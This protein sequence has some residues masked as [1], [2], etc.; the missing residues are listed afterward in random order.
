MQ[1]GSFEFKPALWPTIA[2]LIIVPVFCGMG[3]WQLSRA[4]DKQERLQAYVQSEQFGPANIGLD[5]VFDAQPGKAA[6]CQL[7]PT[8]HSTRPADRALPAP[9][10]LQQQGSD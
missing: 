1:I 4:V 7:W 6:G 10:V 5:Q 3:I 9:V 8:C 2:A